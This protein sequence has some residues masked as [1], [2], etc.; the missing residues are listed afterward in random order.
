MQTD[1]PLHSA[2]TTLFIH[3]STDE[4]AAKDQ[5]RLSQGQGDLFEDD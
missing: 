5:K 4:E 3:P 2:T 1:K